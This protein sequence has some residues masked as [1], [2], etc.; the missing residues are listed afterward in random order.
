M[1]W[2]NHHLFSPV[3]E[4]NSHP[5]HKNHKDC[6][7]LILGYIH[8]GYQISWLSLPYKSQCTE[9]RLVTG[10]NKEVSSIPSGKESLIG[11]LK[12]F[13][14][15]VGILE[16]ASLYFEMVEN[17][18]TASAVA[19]ILC[20]STATFHTTPPGFSENSSAH[21]FVTTKNVYQDAVEWVSSHT[22]GTDSDWLKDSDCTM[23]QDKDGFP[24][25][26]TN[27]A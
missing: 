19:I 16:V 26:L 24:L 11:V 6:L 5:I 4:L 25:T 14:C 27:T 21:P 13:T 8:L 15:W 7:L 2:W 10:S 23:N 22:P 1:W 9:C 3:V 20:G 18:N 17:D 12:G